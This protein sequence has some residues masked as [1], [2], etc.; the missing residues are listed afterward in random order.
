MIELM[1]TVSNSSSN[2]TTV[3]AYVGFLALGVSV[4]GFGSNYLPVKKFETGDGM[5]FQLM[6]TCGIWVV[7]FTVHC[8]RYASRGTSL[9]RASSHSCLDYI[10]FALLCRLLF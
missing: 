3:P 10:I 6:L 7:G 9:F 1:S 8:I 2:D 5:F 4:F